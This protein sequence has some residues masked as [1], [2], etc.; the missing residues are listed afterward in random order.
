MALAIDAF[1]LQ[2]APVFSSY[3]LTLGSRFSEGARLFWK[4]LERDGYLKKRGWTSRLR[5][6]L[7]AHPG[8][9]TRVLYGDRLPSLR[10][11]G[12]IQQV[13][14]IQAPAWHQ[15]PSQPFVP[16]GVALAR[17]ELGRALARTGS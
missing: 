14:G 17:A 9:I 5:S 8:E 15:P 12:R 1:W 11:A 7:G 13:F 3:R 16:P 2:Y 4:K 6:E 10:L